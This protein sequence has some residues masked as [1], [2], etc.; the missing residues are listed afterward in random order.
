MRSLDPSL[1]EGDC[2]PVGSKRISG[3]RHFP[4]LPCGSHVESIALR[5][6]PAD[7]VDRTSHGG[8][9]SCELSCTIPLAVFGGDQNSAMKYLIRT[10]YGLGLNC[11]HIRIERLAAQYEHF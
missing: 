5:T 9:K 11:R 8:R 10:D 1:T 2:A 4:E 6:F 7:N 3:S